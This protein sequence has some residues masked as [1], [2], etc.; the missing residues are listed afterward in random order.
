MSVIMYRDVLESGAELQE[1]VR[2]WRNSDRV[3]L[4]MI[5]TESIEEERHSLWL[6]SLTSTSPGQV[7]RVA[8]D[9]ETPFG[10]IT[11]KDIDRHSSRSDWG[12]YIG[13]ERFLGRGLGRRML[14]DLL[15]WAF[16]EEGLNRLYTSVLADN[17]KALALYLDCG[18]HLEGRF[19]R[20]IR[21]TSGEFVD[22]YWIAMFAQE[23]RRKKTL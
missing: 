2:T 5:S 21:R 16:E 19:E 23:W 6:A 18:F 12:M 8:F 10:I 20:H 14:L 4:S 13:D 11:L 9:G 1:R 15:E 7:V 17:S 22:V 3:R